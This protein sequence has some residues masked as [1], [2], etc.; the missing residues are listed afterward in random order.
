MQNTSFEEDL[1]IIEAAHSGP[2]QI[3]PCKCNYTSCNQVFINITNSDG[4][5]DPENAKMIQ[6]AWEKWPQTI[7]LAIR[8]AQEIEELKAERNKFRE[9]WLKSS[10]DYDSMEKGVIGD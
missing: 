10:D 5:L 3:S 8:Q 6:A 2:I 7:R 9:L 4:R 1:A